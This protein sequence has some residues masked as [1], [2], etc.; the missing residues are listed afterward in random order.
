MGA[1]GYFLLTPTTKR[2]TLDGPD[3]TPLVDLCVNASGYGAIVSVPAG[4]EITSGPPTL[5][6]GPV[7]AVELLRRCNLYRLSSGRP[8]YV[9]PPAL[10][11]RAKSETL[12]GLEALV[13]FPGVAKN[14]FPGSG[15]WSGTGL[16]VSWRGECALE[17]LSTSGFIRKQL[18]IEDAEAWLRANGHPLPWS[19]VMGGVK[20]DAPPAPPD[21]WQIVTR[22]DKRAGSPAPAPDV[23]THGVRVTKE[24][25]AAKAR[26]L[27]EQTVGERKLRQR[28]SDAP[29]ITP[30]PISA[31]VK[32]R[33]ATR[34]RR[35]P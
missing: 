9:I 33:A 34:K 4:A 31:P 6:V 19:T 21:T 28:V 14:Y 20:V 23:S 27:K 11:K 32:K 24:D 3:G 26:E 16:W 25:A 18:T 2:F 15:T 5:K 12:P 30:P 7:E 1:G 10:I 22:G 17:M 8:P 29:T 13:A 35:R